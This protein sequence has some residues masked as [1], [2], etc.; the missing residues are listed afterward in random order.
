[1]VSTKAKEMGCL[2]CKSSQAN[3][4]L[5]ENNKSCPG[6]QYQRKLHFEK[7][8]LSWVF[9][10]LRNEVFVG[11]ILFTKRSPPCMDA[12]KSFIYFVHRYRS[13]RTTSNLLVVNLAAGD[14]VMCVVD[15]PL[16]AV[17]SFFNFWPFGMNGE[18]SLFTRPVCV[19]CC[20]VLLQKI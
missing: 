16:F 13:L 3:N 7:M 11:I 1:M 5:Y 10:C 9:S 19:C 8:W 17:A 20:L 2:L 14:L 6:Q 4:I 15:F 12:L 18:W